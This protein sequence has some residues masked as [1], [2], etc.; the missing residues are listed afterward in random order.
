[1]ADDL[2]E[3]YAVLGRK[4]ANFPG[5][6]SQVEAQLGELFKQGLCRE[7]GLYWLAQYPRYIKAALQRMQKHLAKA[8]H[9]ESFTR[10]IDGF[11]EALAGL[12]R[13]KTHYAPAD[14][15][16]IQVF[17]FMIEEYR[18]SHYAQHLKTAVPVSGKR[19]AK[20][21]QKLNERLA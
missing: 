5:P 12:R 3:L 20:Q 10:E 4:R 21:W 17:R 18:V 2:V 8:D 13:G 1:M 11:T 14:L 15:R 16:E 6:S 7:A 9:E 19:L